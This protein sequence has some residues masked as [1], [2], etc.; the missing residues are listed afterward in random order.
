MFIWIALA[1][2]VLLALAAYSVGRRKV[3]AAVGGQTRALHS[4]PGYYGAFLALWV[5]APEA[6]LLLLAIVLGGRVEEAALRADNPAAVAAL[7]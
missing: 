4:L 2:L 3:L 5:A 7:P 1:G 6:I